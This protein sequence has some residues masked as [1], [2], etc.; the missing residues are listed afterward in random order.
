MADDRHFENSFITISQP[1]ITDFNK[2]WYV[3]VDCA[4]NLTKYKNFAN[5]KWRTAAKLKIVFWLYITN[6]YPINAKFCRIKQN[7]VLRQVI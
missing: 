3:D 1:E 7:R 2:I 4:S 6:D 5:S